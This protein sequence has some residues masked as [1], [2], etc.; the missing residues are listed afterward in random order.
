MLSILIGHNVYEG[1]LIVIE[2][3]AHRSRWET[4]EV[5]FGV[6]FLISIGLHL[7]CPFV[8]FQGIFRLAFIPIGIILVV[9]G[10]SCIVLARREFALHDQPTDTGLPTKKIV[11]SGV[12]SISRNPL[13]LG[14]IIVLFGIAL[15]FN[16][17]WAVI[18]LIPSIIISH[19]VLIFPEERYLTAK[20]GEEYKEYAVSVHRWLGRK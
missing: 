5:V 15:I 7:A 19:Y 8:L 3:V 2:E 4:S 12:F 18:I 13:Y 20:F 16:M 10:V 1:Y 9:V 6:P 17:L 11:S 14:S